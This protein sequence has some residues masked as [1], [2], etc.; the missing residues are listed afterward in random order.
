MRQP[1]PPRLATA[2]VVGIAAIVVAGIA[3]G[4]TA[5]AADEPSFVIT[6]RGFGHGIGMSQYGAEGLAGRGASYR[7]ILGHYY[8][9]TTLGRVDRDVRVRVLVAAPAGATASA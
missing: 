2:C 6:G 4:T 7:S 8:R 1:G 5:R 9:G 3:T